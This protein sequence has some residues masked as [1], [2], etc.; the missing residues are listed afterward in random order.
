M[1]ALHYALEGYPGT[2]KV[3]DQINLRRLAIRA[4]T[5][6]RYVDGAD[7]V[8]TQMAQLL[9]QLVNLTP[10]GMANLRATDPDHALLLLQEGE[11]YLPISVEMA[12][13]YRKAGYERSGGFDDVEAI[14]LESAI[15][16][17]SATAEE[18]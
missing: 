5:F 17:G 10:Q 3:E 8:I 18:D 11:K 12:E 2:T 9:V 15:K 4:M 14:D 16:S 6:S 1:D 7:E 13:A